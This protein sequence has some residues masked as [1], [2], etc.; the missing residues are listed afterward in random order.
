V[1]NVFNLIFY[2]SFFSISIFFS[3]QIELRANLE[4]IIYIWFDLSEGSINNKVHDG[5]MDGGSLLHQ[6]QMLNRWVKREQKGKQTKPM[7][8]WLNATYHHAYSE[9]IAQPFGDIQ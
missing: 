6:H 9:Q 5:W 1:N 2:F 7:F 8:Q 3:S 4:M